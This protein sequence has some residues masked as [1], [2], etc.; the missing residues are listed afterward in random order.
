MPI[1]ACR[2]TVD[3]L[4]A[5]TSRWRQVEEAAH[6][7]AQRFGYKEIRTPAFEVTELFTESLGED[8]DI[9]ERE[10]YTF[11]DKSGR[12]LT[13]RPELT[14]PTVRAY[15][16]H[17]LGNQQHCKSYYL[18]EIWRYERPQPGRLR[19]AHQFGLEAL[20]SASPAVD[21]E[22]VDVAF[23]FFQEL[24]LKD[25]RLEVNSIGC[26]KCRPAYQAVLRDFFAGKDDVLCQDC[27]RR[28]ERNPLRV[29]DCKK[30]ACLAVTNT[31]PTVFQSLC[32]DCKN[33]FFTFKEHLAQMG[34]AVFGNPRV[35]HGLSYY[36][37]T[38]FQI[39]STHLGPFNPLCAGGRFDELVGQLGASA[40]PAMG[41]ACG[42]ERTILAMEKESVAAPEEPKVDAFLVGIGEEAERIMTRTMH[43]LRK[44]GYRVERDYMARG[45]KNQLKLA[46]KMT[47]SYTIIVGE[48][49]A[50][51]TQVQ[52]SDNVRGTQETINV[53]RLI[54]AVEFRLRRDQRD[55]GRRDRHEVDEVRRGR[56]ERGREE[57]GERG[58]G[59][60]RYRGRERDREDV[61]RRPREAERGDEAVEAARFAEWAA[62]Y[63]EAARSAVPRPHRRVPLSELAFAD[64]ES[65]MEMWSAAQVGL[66]E[67][68]RPVD[69]P[70]PLQPIALAAPLPP[71]RA[72]VHPPMSDAPSSGNWLLEAGA[73]V[74]EEEAPLAFEAAQRDPLS[75]RVEG[76]GADLD[77]DADGDD[78]GLDDDDEG[79]EGSLA[80]AGARAG[81]GGDAD[82]NGEKRRR[83]GRRGGRRHGRRKTRGGRS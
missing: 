3:I 70:W 20:G 73:E 45:L 74:E 12:S 48:E 24:G 35:V 56:D 29:L 41:F 28:K 51:V 77:Y 7:I 22:L 32:S 65:G 60:D 42:L 30:D 46:E 44:R 80:T 50:R 9:I 1:T 21:A 57:F 55:K 10:L 31:A 17:N 23:T 19:E 38:V 54:D 62:T 6:R 43:Q 5:E 67:A 16:E 13:L 82:G 81:G 8:T 78:E 14:V 34:Y 53:G 71:R 61:E 59:R 39:H 68:P 11:R 2:G 18:G 25:L 47:P 66:A 64:G 40:T 69:G 72:P 83:G 15:L 75:D 26:K 27:E 52:V 58:R 33:H 63:A 37:R 79:E 4:P 76:D 36:T 49:D